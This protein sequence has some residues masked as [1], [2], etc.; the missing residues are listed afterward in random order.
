LLS[1][2]SADALKLTIFLALPKK[3][4]FLAFTPP[5]NTPLHRKRVVFGI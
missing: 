5:M 4:L 3:A 1:A 2:W